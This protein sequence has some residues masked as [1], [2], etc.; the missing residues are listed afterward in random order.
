MQ[1]NQVQPTGDVETR[2]DFLKKTA[3]ATAAVTA[4]GLFKTPVYG[5]STA[6]ST[7]RVIGANDRIAVAY[8]GVGGQGMAHVRSQKAHAGDNNIAQ[9]AV[10]DIWKKR[11]QESKAY[12]E[13]ENSGA[14]VEAFE[15]YRKLL[16][17][18]DI[19]AVVVSTVDHWHT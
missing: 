2:R 9:I 10:C 6:P 7:G 18:K 5:Q 14:K 11:L 16:D 3:S 17:H 1:K 15:D 19:D 8:I 13:N 12:I 4:T